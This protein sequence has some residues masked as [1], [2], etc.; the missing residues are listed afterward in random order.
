MK[1]ANLILAQTNHQKKTLKANLGI[2]SKV[3]L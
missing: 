3:F 1:Q 2:E